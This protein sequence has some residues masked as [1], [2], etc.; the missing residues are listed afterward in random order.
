MQVDDGEMER[1]WGDHLAGLAIGTEDEDRAQCFVATH[2]LGQAGSER[3]DVG[4]RDTAPAQCQDHVR[5]RD[6]V[7]KPA[8]QVA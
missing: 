1:A 8:D 5:I 3:P 2:G 7:A 4:W 6:W